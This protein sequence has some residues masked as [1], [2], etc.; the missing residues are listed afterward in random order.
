MSRALFIGDL[1]VDVMMGGMESLPVV[2][3][4]VACQS[5]DV[6]MGASTVLCACAY[7]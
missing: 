2:D 4:E 1:N 3:R 6:V 7:A 5:Y